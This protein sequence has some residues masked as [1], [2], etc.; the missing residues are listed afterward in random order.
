MQNLR[1]LSSSKE[2]RNKDSLELLADAINK[3]AGNKTKS[4]DTTTS[5]SWIS[6]MGPQ[7]GVKFRGGAPPVPPT[8][9]YQASDLRA[10]EKFERK[11]KV[12]E[13]QA[14][15]YMTG[16]EAA[17]TLFTSLKGEAEQELEFVDVNTIYKKGG[18]DVILNHLKQAFQQK[19]VYIKR[20]Y[21][22]MSMKPLDDGQVN[23]CGPSSIVIVVVSPPCRPL[24]LTSA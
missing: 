13:L 2:G 10:F 17:L 23:L 3:L 24:A 1:A 21:T 15:H 18:V 16:A 19:N 11:V 4:N 7:K 22:C 12:W 5:S 9:S 6:A 8:W 14:S 20:Q